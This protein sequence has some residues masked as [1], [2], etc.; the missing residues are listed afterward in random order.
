VDVPVRCTLRPTQE[1]LALTGEIA[2]APLAGPETVVFEVPDPR[3]WVTDARVR[4]DGNRLIAVSEL[5]AG[6]GGPVSLDRSRIRITVIGR[7]EAVEI[8]GCSG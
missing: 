6:G 1:G 2:I 4:R 3:L 7:R 8:M 5:M